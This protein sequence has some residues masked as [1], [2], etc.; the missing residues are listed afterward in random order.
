MSKQTVRIGSRDWPDYIDALS[1]V[2]IICRRRKWLETKLDHRGRT[3]FFCLKKTAVT[4]R[5]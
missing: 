5:R 3:A 4:D 2:I 1:A